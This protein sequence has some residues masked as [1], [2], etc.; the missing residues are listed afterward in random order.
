MMHDNGTVWRSSV[1]G[2]QMDVCFVLAFRSQ[3]RRRGRKSCAVGA[4]EKLSI[5]SAPH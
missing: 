3:L 5:D 1:E 2:K 4:P